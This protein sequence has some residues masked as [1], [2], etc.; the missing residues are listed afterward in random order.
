MSSEVE[1]ITKEYQDFAYIVSHDLN[2]PLRHV[3][4]FTRLIIGSRQNDNLNEE[5]KE[6]IQFLEQ[7]LSRLDEM[8]KAL[9]QFSRITTQGQPFENID[10]NAVVRRVVDDLSIEFENIPEPI[11]RFANLPQCYGDPVQIYSVF[12]HL[13]SNAAKFHKENTIPEID[14]TAQEEGVVLTF[15]IKDNGIG[16]EAGKAEE[17]FRIFRK[18]HDNSKYIGAGIGLTLSKKIIERHNGKIWVESS[19]NQ[20]STVY[21]TL[22][23]HA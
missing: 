11:M 8:Q 4:E 10:T 14:I 5:E 20:G 21:F 23:K 2:A 13:I 19:P 1:R 6:Y 12:Y 17:I 22:P 16:L 3:R 15:Q 9:M 18:L 7:S